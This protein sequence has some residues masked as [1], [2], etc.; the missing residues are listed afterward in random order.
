[1]LGSL[2]WAAMTRLTR[3]NVLIASGGL[4]LGSP[5]MA[6]LRQTSKPEEIRI[7]VVGIRNRGRA[8]INAF[9]QLPGVTVVALCDVDSK[10]LEREAAQFQERGEEVATYIDYRDLLERSDLHAVVLATP[11]HWHA[12]Q[13]IWACQAGLDVF[14]EKP[15]SHSMLEGVMMVE[16]ARKHN[17][18]VQ[19]GTQSRSSH[20][21]RDAIAWMQGGTIGRTHVARGFCYKPRRSIGKVDGPQTVPPHIDYDRWTGP[22][23][24]VPLARKELHYDWHWDTATGNGDLGNQGVHQMDMC[25]WALG[26]DTMPSRVVS[27]GGRF[28]Y[29]DDGNT[30]NTQVLWA[31]YPTGPICFEVRGL[32]R[33]SASQDDQWPASMDDY[34][35]VRIG[36]VIE[37]E[38]GALHI[39]NYHSAKAFDRSG[40]EIKSW[41]GASSH[42]AN[43]IDAVRSRKTSDL[44]ADIIEGHRSAAPCHLGMMWHQLGSP[45]EFSSLT[46]MSKSP[47]LQDAIDRM[48]VHLNANGV[49][50]NATPMTY[51][52]SIKTDH[53][54]PMFRQGR[55]PYTF[56]A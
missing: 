13:T 33:D 40:V 24:L 14:V 2:R 30:P 55:P 46:T 32:P 47:V 35:G 42:A 41:E 8:H 19:T 56:P 22:A 27:F 15:V 37:C 9:R 16:A 4:A 36:C 6:L 20:A 29:D 26:A 23:P 7:A 49:D 45:I 5:A 17:R 38:G 39:P 3:R 34:K 25:R 12:L 21:I 48:V 53:I 31:E 50:L 51:G 54:D 11:N 10:I 43:F 1:M 52:R 44:T 18:I 28:G